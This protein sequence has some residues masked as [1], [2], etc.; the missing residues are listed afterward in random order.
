MPFVA[1]RLKAWSNKIEP[2]K[3]YP[4]DVALGL[5]QEFA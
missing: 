3:T 4:I 2:G 1:K 5:V